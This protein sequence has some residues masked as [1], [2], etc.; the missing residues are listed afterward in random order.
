LNDVELVAAGPVHRSF[1]EAAQSETAE[2]SFGAPITQ[3][4]RASWGE[5]L[6]RALSDPDSRVRVIQIDGRRVGYFWLERRPESV[7]HLLDFFVA[8]A[9]RRTGIGGRLLDSAVENAADLG[10]SSLRLVV[11]RSNSPAEAFFRKHG[12]RPLGGQGD[13]A[14]VEYELSV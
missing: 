4:Q 10:C 9:D 11:S 13:D 8:P 12:A 5:A 7:A 14:R 3:E 6:E 2:L 1:I